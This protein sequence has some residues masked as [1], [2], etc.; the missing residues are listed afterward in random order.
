[1]FVTAFCFHLRCNATLYHFFDGKCLATLTITQTP[2]ILNVS[3]IAGPA[4]D[5]QETQVVEVAPA[6]I[7]EKAAEAEAAEQ[8]AEVE[9][10]E[11]PLADRENEPQEVLHKKRKQTHKH[12]FPTTRV[13]NRDLE[14]CFTITPDQGTTM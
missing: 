3:M 11:I 13:A 14:N 5:A 6:D 9:V 8:V 7:A 12:K 1:M 4:M 10:P 2:S